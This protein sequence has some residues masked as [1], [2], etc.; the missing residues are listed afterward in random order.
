MRLLFSFDFY[1]CLFLVIY[2]I[3][4]CIYMVLYSEFRDVDDILVIFGI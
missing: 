2:E 1:N 4:G 3:K